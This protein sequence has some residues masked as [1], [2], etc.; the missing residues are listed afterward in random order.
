VIAL[1]LKV[2]MQQNG[3][4]RIGI[5]QQQPISAGHRQRP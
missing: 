2:L 5:E 4:R 1:G 3:P